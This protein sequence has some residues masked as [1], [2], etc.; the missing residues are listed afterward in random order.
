MEHDRSDELLSRGWSRGFAG[1]FWF[2]DIPDGSGAT[3][4]FSFLATFPF[5]RKPL[6]WINLFDFVKYYINSPNYVRSL[7]CPEVRRME[8]KNTIPSFLLRGMKQG[9]DICISYPYWV[10]TFSLWIWNMLY[11]DTTHDWAGKMHIFSHLPTDTEDLFTENTR[12]LP[13]NS[14]T[15]LSDRPQSPC[16]VLLA[17][18]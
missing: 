9:I 3:A 13:T 11:S 12:T 16:L 6:V 10:W 8:E 4:W 15:Y 1:S 7:Y 2:S 17:P 5:F 18:G 14:N